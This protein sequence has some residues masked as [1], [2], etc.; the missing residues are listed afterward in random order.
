MSAAATSTKKLLKEWEIGQILETNEYDK[1]SFK[2]GNRRIDQNHLAYV[3]GKMKEEYLI[4]PIM[5]NAKMEIMDGQHRFMACRHLN[6]P[7]RYYI[8]D[9]MDAEEIARMNNVAKRWK[10]EDYANVFTGEDYKSYRAFRTTYPKIVHTIA[11]ILLGGVENKRHNGDNAFRTGYFKVK[12]YSK[13]VAVA[14][15]IMQIGDY[16]KESTKRSF[17]LALLHCMTFKEFDEKRLLRKIK[18]RANLL[19]GY[20]RVDEFIQAIQE[21]YNWMEQKENK[22]SF[23]KL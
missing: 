18:H 6:L 1:F 19:R 5:V 11:V 9:D 4:A 23:A 17:V 3:E 16:T 15:L 10:P 8:T 12:S 22:V 14:K 2:P 20:A 21:I 13:A 7:V